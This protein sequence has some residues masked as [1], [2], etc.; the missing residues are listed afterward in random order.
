MYSLPMLGLYLHSLRNTKI[1]FGN[2]YSPVME[3]SV[4][5]SPDKL[6]DIIVPIERVTPGKGQPLNN[7]RAHY[8]IWPDVYFEAG[9]VRV[10]CPM[11]SSQV[12]QVPNRL[13]HMLLNPR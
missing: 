5:F 4:T 11:S 9:R 10:Y 1:C 2:L 12:L 6:I 7:I 8:G 13:L 3:N